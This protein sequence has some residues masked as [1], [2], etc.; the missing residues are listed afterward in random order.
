MEQNQKPKNLIISFILVALFIFG[1]IAYTNYYQNKNNQPNPEVSQEE[2]DSISN[3]GLNVTIPKNING[4]SFKIESILDNNER[5]LLGCS[6]VAFEA[7]AGVVYVKDGNGNDVSKPTPLTT[8]MDWM[9]DDPVLYTANIQ[10][11]NG[12]TGDAIVI[13]NE[14]NP[15][16]EMVSKTISFPINIQ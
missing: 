6:W 7:Q 16:D 3:C 11:L 4:G 2:K 9:T 8:A 1:L 10:I 12:Y 14:E 5:E 13:I 15:S